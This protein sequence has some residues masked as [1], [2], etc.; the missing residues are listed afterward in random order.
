MLSA[1][2]FDFDGVIADSEP[3]HYRSFR[4]VLMEEGVELN[5]AD[6]YERY[7][8]FS[9]AGA[10]R[11]IGTDRARPWTADQLAALASRKA[12]RFQQLEHVSSVL[13]PGAEA[14]VRR[15][16]AAVPLAIASGALRAEITRVL[17]RADLMRCFTAIVAAGETPASKPAPD[18]YLRALALL[19]AARHA[20]L[21][22]AE[23]VAIEDSRWGLESA[24]TAGLRTVAV[25]HAYDR[26]TLAAADLVITDVAALDLAVLHRLCSPKSAQRHD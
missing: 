7:L 13:F 8:G 2:V 23:C 3:L 1:I 12:L 10:F 16:A 25:T 20:P 17:D 11:A 5:E 21:D 19:S 18:P 9:D 14:A 6:Y 4:D 15:A 26:A 22:P 24:R